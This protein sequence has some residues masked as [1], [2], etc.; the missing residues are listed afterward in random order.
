MTGGTS[1]IASLIGAAGPGGRRGRPA[2]TASNL[3]TT[4]QREE[5]EEGEGHAVA[6]LRR[7]LPGRKALW[8]LQHWPATGGLAVKI[9]AL[10]NPC[11][12]MHVQ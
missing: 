5:E 4:M 3:A 11:G 2:G 10:P 8:S 7:D 9:N 6:P 1:Y 12:R